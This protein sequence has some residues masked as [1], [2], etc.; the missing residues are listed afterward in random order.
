MTVGNVVKGKKGIYINHN[1]VTGGSIELYIIQDGQLMQVDVEDLNKH[2][3]TSEKDAKS[4][5]EAVENKKQ[6]VD[7]NGDKKAEQGND[8]KQN[9]ST[10]Y[11][12]ELAKYFPQV[13]GTVLNYYGTVEYGQT[14]TL[15]KVIKEDS[16]MTLHFKGEIEDLSDGEGPSREE[17]ILEPSYTITEN[18]VKESYK[19]K[20]RF[21]QSIINGF[22][23]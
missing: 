12:R 17:R 3:E 19:N 7:D 9:V 4:Q 2:Q 22:P 11:S 8:T 10:S 21:P 5:V 1:F 13:E 14:L 18:S 15:S 6:N 20:R 23:V 16:Q